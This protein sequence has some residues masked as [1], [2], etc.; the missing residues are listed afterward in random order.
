M[1]HKLSCIILSVMARTMAII[2]TAGVIAAGDKVEPTNAVWLIA[3]AA[4]GWW[5]ADDYA[6]E[7]RSKK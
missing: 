1:I 5:C 7:A 4:W 3:V 2:L 6:H